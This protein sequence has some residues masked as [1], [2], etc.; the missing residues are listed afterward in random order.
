MV[1]RVSTTG[2][3]AQNLSVITGNR[4]K[5]D[6]LNFSLSSGLNFEGL[7]F[8]GKDATRIV[9]LEKDIEARQSYIRSIDITQTTT[10]SY[11]AVLERLVEVATDALSAAE[12]LSTADVDFPTT[13]T[14]L[15]N[16]F[17][18]EFEA[19]L[20]IKIGDRFIFAGTNFTQ[21]PVT[22]L[23]TLSLYTT[24]DL[25]SNG[26][27]L[28]V[29]ETGDQIPEHV[30]DQGGAG[31]IESYHT[32]FA[33]T[34]TIDSNASETM[35]VTIN[36]S[37]P[38]T[39]TITAT[40][41][42]FQN[43]VEGL[44][45]LKSGAQAGLTED[46]RDEFLGEARNVLELARTQLRQL[47]ASSGTISNELQRTKEIHQGFITISQ[48]ALDDLTVAD[49]AEVAVKIASLQNQLEASFTTIARQSQ[50]SLV[51]FLR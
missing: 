11:D 44:L 34:G 37:Q 25:V 45:R 7:K 8:Y 17:M 47:Q 40:E 42:A 14:V 48:V 36:D 9:N 22:D 16:N 12:P 38:I 27:T 15:A 31:T 51:N 10:S 19:N 26:A 28:N 6:S 18:L 35:Q 2:I 33:G 41:S 1:S 3:L 43:M 21:P 13:A 30:V 49:E 39:H 4:S 20:N 46:E 29:I 50:L 23:R 24:N 32:S 5:L